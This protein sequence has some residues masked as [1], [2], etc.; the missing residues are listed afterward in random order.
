MTTNDTWRNPPGSAFDG[1]E[2]HLYHRRTTTW[3]AAIIAASALLGWYAPF[4]VQFAAVAALIIA[5]TLA[6]LK[7]ET[8]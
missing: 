7:E 1:R 3:I 4:S 6:V 5:L 2:N 8:S